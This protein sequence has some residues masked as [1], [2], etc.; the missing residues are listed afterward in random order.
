MESLTEFDIQ[1]IHNDIAQV[2]ELIMRKTFIWEM[3]TDEVKRQE[4][5]AELQVL[6]E[7]KRALETLVTPA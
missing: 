2:N 5:T 7:R 1:R 6:E 4:L 3:E